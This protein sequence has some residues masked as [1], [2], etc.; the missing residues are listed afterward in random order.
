MTLNDCLIY[1]L[2]Y[3][4]FSIYFPKDNN[5]SLT[6]RRLMIQQNCTIKQPSN[7]DRFKFFTRFRRTF[8]EKYERALGS[9]SWAK[10]FPLNYENTR[11]AIKD[12]FLEVAQ[13]LTAKTASSASGSS[14][15]ASGNEGKVSTGK[16]K[17]YK[18]EILDNLKRMG[19]NLTPVNDRGDCLFQSLGIFLKI[20]VFS[21]VLIQM[22]IRL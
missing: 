19:W 10:Q 4:E 5:W 7:V 17:N 6:C 9:S 20:K 1:L 22:L 13:E 3:L 8:L 11:K 15:S 2:C 14:K 16:N 12:L 21:Q 18:P